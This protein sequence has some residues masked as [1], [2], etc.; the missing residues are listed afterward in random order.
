M[1]LNGSRLGA[2]AVAVGGVVVLAASG[3]SSKSN[4]NAPGVTSGSGSHPATADVTITNLDP[5][6]LLFQ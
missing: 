5:R 1:A 6:D 4:N 2:V 3:S